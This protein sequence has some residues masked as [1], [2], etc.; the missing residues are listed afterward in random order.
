MAPRQALGRRCRG[1]G[2][3]LGSGME[4]KDCHWQAAEDG[5]LLCA[6]SST[7]GMADSQLPGTSGVRSGGGLGSGV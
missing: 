1:R 4:V 6:I 5:L 3:H 2:Q 7:A